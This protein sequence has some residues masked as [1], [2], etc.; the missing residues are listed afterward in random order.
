MDVKVIV[1]I[2]ILTV[3]IIVSAAYLLKVNKRQKPVLISGSLFELFDFNNIAGIDFIRNKIVVSFT[4]ASL[5][6][7]NKLKELGGKGISIVGDK[8][9]FFISDKP[10]ENEQLYND[11][12]KHIER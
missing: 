6:D 2:A 3:I 4:D 8:I 11:L 1:I 7:V 12:L 5:F 9:K 10:Q